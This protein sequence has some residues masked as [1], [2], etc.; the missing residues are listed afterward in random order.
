MAGLIRQFA[1]SLLRSAEVSGPPGGI[2]PSYPPRVKEPFGGGYGARPYGASMPVHEPRYGEFEGE[3]YRPAPTESHGW[4]GPEA[5]MVAQEPP[6]RIF[7]PDTIDLNLISERARLKAEGVRWAL[8]VSAA[9]GLVAFACFW[10][11]R[12]TIREDTVS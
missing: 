8:I 7:G 1:M 5:G 3:Y 9:S 12:K 11:A 4:G 6:R 10:L 2:A